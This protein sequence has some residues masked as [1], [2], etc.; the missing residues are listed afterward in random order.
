M[1]NNDSKST[2]DLTRRAA[3]GAIGAGALVLSGRSVQAQAAKPT[4]IKVG[5]ATYLS[6]PASVFG[7]P[8]RHAA[9][10]LFEELNAAGGIGGVR[11][12]PIFFDEGPGVDH[13][14]AE[15]RR[16][17]QSD[18]VDLM[19]AAISSADCLACA[20]IAEEMKRPTLLWDCGTQRIFEEAR[21]DYAFRTQGYGTP[22]V[23]APLLYLLKIQAKFPHGGGGQP[24][25]RLGPRLLGDVE[26]S[27]GRAQARRARGG[28]D[29]PPLRL[30]RLFHGDHP[31]ARTTPDVVFHARGVAISSP[32]FARRPSAGCLSAPPSC[33]RWRRPR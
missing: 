2:N 6:G 11:I 14:V 30:D 17:V 16:L 7:V 13:F 3:L 22:E 29:V 28:R 10:L 27:G 12:R 18:K 9:E 4:E 33:C 5:I 21:Y 31:P 15:Y 24:G 25:L 20:P 32:S 26:D 8:A 1:T 23:L 19:F